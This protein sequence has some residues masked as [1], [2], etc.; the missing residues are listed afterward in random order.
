MNLVEYFFFKGN[1]ISDINS[2][3][4]VVISYVLFGNSFIFRI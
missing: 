3:Y 2:F 4:S 1:F